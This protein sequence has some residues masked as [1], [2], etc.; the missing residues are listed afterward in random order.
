MPRHLKLL[1]IAIRATAVLTLLLGIVIWTGRRVPWTSAHMGL[2]VLVGILLIAIGVAVTRST[3]RIGATLI[4]VAWLVILVA[5][6]IG[7][8]RV[9][10]GDAHWVAQVV[11]VLLGL[12]TIG[13]AERMA[14][15]V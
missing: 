10:P 4:A 12:A 8:T 6:G 3:G 1:L 5:Y 13:V 14:R 7:H 2:G 9:L 15:R 11:H